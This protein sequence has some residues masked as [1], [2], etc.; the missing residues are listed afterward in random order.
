[1]IEYRFERRDRGDEGDGVPPGLA[2]EPV[3]DGGFRGEEG[4]RLATCTPYDIVE[5]DDCALEGSAVSVVVG[6]TWDSAS[7]AFIAGSTGGPP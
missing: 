6:V 3:R 7:G 1:M 5:F 4:H 2:R